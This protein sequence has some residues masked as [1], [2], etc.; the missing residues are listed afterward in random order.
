MATR[1]ATAT[2]TTTR[3]AGA[4][5]LP[6]RQ[7]AVD[8]ALADTHVLA[9]GRP[10]QTQRL[11]YLDHDLVKTTKP[12]QHEQNKLNVLFHRLLPQVL[13]PAPRP[14]RGQEKFQS[15]VP[16]KSRESEGH[17]GTKGLERP[18]PTGHR[19][20]WVLLFAR[21]AEEAKQQ[22]GAS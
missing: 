22:E 3:L 19:S 12:Q 1:L 11:T 18:R 8:P 13:R 10:M 16:T 9:D 6:H 4:S 2:V 14:Q 17:S 20:T 5:G 7:E 21:F 15:E